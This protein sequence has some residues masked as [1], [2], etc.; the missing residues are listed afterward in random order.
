M[1]TVENQPDL[2]RYVPTKLNSCLIGASK[3]VVGGKGRAWQQTPYRDVQKFGRSSYSYDPSPGGSQGKGEPP[4]GGLAQPEIFLP[5]SR[6]DAEDS[7]ATHFEGE[8]APDIH[9]VSS[10]PIPTD[11]ET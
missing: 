6:K 1:G 8:T 11:P 5:I 10:V 4:T 7:S 9:F 2:S 3:S